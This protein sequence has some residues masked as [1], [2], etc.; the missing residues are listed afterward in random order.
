MIKLCGLDK[1]SGLCL[2]CDMKPFETFEASESHA[3]DYV[4]EIAMLNFGIIG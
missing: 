4:L 3:T 1:K 2:A